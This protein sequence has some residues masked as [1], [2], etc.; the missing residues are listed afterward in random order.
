MDKLQKE[1][2]ELGSD[3]PDIDEAPDACS[4]ASL[5]SSESDGKLGDALVEVE[6][7]NADAISRV[8]RYGLVEASPTGS[9]SSQPLASTSAASTPVAKV[10]AATLVAPALV[11]SMAAAPP[12]TPVATLVGP[13]SAPAEASLTAVAGSGRNSTTDRANFAKFTRLI[14]N[15]RKCPHLLAEE[16][17]KD[18]INAFNL[19]LDANMDAEAVV[20]KLIIKR[21]ATKLSAGGDHF[22]TMKKR[23]LEKKYSADKVASVIAHCEKTKCVKPDPYFP[24]DPDETYYLIFDSSSLLLG[25]EVKESMTAEAEQSLTT[26]QLSDIVGPDGLL[27]A[28]TTASVGSFGDLAS[29]NLTDLVVPPGSDGHKRPKLK[30]QPEL[31]PLPQAPLTLEAKIQDYAMRAKKESGAAR[32]SAIS[33]AGLDVAEKLVSMAKKHAAICEGAYKRLQQMQR[34]GN[35]SEVEFAA[36]FGLL[37]KHFDTWALNEKLAKDFEMSMAPKD[38]GSKQKGK[39]KGKP[40]AKALP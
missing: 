6:K 2:L 35:K 1:L 34:N 30:P 22:L 31:N 36:V 39:G 37:D 32:W 17:D 28:T 24:K 26:A 29:S 3:L 12:A 15:P 21:T 40:C 25:N 8:L 33:L 7:L 5:E 10:P 23:D 14:A 27:T 18:K 13:A 20:A 38:G 11:A 4:E 16:S 19:W 9:A